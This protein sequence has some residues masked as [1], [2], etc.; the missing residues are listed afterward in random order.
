MT[1]T[2]LIDRIISGLG[3][4]DLEEADTPAIDTLG[5][6]EFGDPPSGAFN[7]GSLMGMIWYLERHTRPDLG[8]A[9]SQCARFTFNPKRSHELALI[10]IGQYLKKTRTKGIIYKPFDSKKLELEAHV[11][12][13][14]MGIYGK[15]Q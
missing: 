14:F 7:Y 4:D 5:K 8:F 13:D 10:R 1:Q 15:E 2:G 6:D 11:D 12:A 9:A 3:C